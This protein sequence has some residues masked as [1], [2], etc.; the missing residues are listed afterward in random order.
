MT[1]AIGDRLTLRCAIQNPTGQ[2][3]QVQWRA[4]DDAMLGF[5]RGVVPGFPRY[6]IVG[7]QAAGEYHL[8]IEN[9]CL[10]PPIP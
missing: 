9:V 2:A 7:D 1:V 3:V 4:P 6:S 5:V 8:S 10:S